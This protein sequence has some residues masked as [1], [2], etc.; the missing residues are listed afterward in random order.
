[1]TELQAIGE[2]F[3]AFAKAEDTTIQEVQAMW[4]RLGAEGP[5][6]L[7][8]SANNTSGERNAVDAI[9]SGLA[10]AQNDRTR[11]PRGALGTAKGYLDT[12]AHASFPNATLV[13]GR[14]HAEQNL[15]R[16]IAPQLTRDSVFYIAG[17]KDPCSQ[18]KPRMRGYQQRLTQAGHANMFQY[19]DGGRNQN[20]LERDV[21]DQ[22]DVDALEVP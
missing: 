8:A 11:Y 14:S 17:T 3:R 12:R 9:A 18:C 2:A 6:L 5:L 4:Y 21:R 20:V 19:G 7:A 15:L 13:S 1:M 22:V 16:W 10:K